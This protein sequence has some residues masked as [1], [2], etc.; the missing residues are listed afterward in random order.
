MSM[1][2]CQKTGL[3]KTEHAKMYVYSGVFCLLNMGYIDT[4]RR[5]IC[6]YNGD[7]KKYS[8]F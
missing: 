8:E 2:I 4:L 3:F 6:M 5:V 7:T 1:I